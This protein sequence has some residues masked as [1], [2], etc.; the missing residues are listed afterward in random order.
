MLNL[1]TSTSESRTIFR[2]LQGRDGY[3][4]IDSFVNSLYDKC[5]NVMLRYL[6]EAQAALAAPPGTSSTPPPNDAARG[7]QGGLAHG[8]AGDGGE[9][10]REEEDEEEEVDPLRKAMIEQS[11]RVVQLFQQWDLDGDGRITKDEFLKV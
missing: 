10:S 4:S 5:N 9:G 7:S 6:A 3:M 1:N 2:S 11:S 8:L